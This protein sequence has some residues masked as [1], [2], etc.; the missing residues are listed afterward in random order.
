MSQAR[1]VREEAAAERAYQRAMV[2]E[3][4]AEMEKRELLRQGLVDLEQV[5][6]D[7][8]LGRDGSRRLHEAIEKLRSLV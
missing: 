7:L 4:P 3:K 2:A 6:V 5:V 1:E 8:Q